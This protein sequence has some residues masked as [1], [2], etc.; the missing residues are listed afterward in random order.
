[1]RTITNINAQAENIYSVLNN[2]LSEGGTTRHLLDCLYP[3]HDGKA[4][5]EAA[6]D[7]VIMRQNLYS[8]QMACEKSIERLTE[9]IDLYDKNE[10]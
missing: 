4:D 1:M 10:E 8:L 3:N 2:W 9:V 5:H 7:L 6:A